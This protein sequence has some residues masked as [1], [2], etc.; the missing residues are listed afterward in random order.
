MT[1]L[2]ACLI[3]FQLASATQAELDDTN[4]AASKSSRN[5]NRVAINAPDTIEEKRSVIFKRSS[6]VF[7]YPP[8]VWNEDEEEGDEE[9]TE[10]DLE[11][12]DAPIKDHSQEEDVEEDEMPMQ[13]PDMADQSGDVQQGYTEDV[14]MDR[15]APR[16]TSAIPPTLQAGNA[17]GAPQPS[18][19]SPVKTQPDQQLPLRNQSSQER[20][21]AQQAEA[22]DKRAAPMLDPAEETGTRKLVITP[23]IARD[24]PAQEQPKQQ[25]Q[26]GPGPLL[27]SAI[28]QKRQEQM[29]LE[30]KRAR[31]EI[32]AA[33]E[34]SRR[35]GTAAKGI[36]IGLGQPPVQSQVQPQKELVRTPS[37]ETRSSSGSGSGGGKLRK[38]RSEKDSD[39]SE[40]DGGKKKKGMFGGLFS[41]NKNK[42]KGGKSSIENIAAVAAGT[43]GRQRTSEE[44]GATSSTHSHTPSSLTASQE[45]GRNAPSPSPAGRGQ[46]QQRTVTPIPQQQTPSRSMAASPPPNNGQQQTQPLTLQVSQHA[47][48]LRDRDQQQQA[49]YSEY[50]KRSP[51]SPPDQPSYA[52]QP[53]SL[54]MPMSEAGSITNSPN[55]SGYGLGLAPVNSSF[56]TQGGRPGSLILTP[57][58]GGD[59]QGSGVP[60]LSVIRVFAGKNLQ[61]EATFK[62]VLLNTSTTAADLVR[63]SMQRFRLAAGE[64]AAD[65]YL[66]VKQVEGTSLRLKPEEKPLGVFE[67]LVEE[68]EEM[69]LRIKRSSMGSI[70]SI[71]SNLSALPAIRKLPMNDFTDDSAVKFYL[72]RE[73][74]DD[75]PTNDSQVQATD[76]PRTEGEALKNGQY[77]SVST[78]GLNTVEPERFSSPALRFAMQLVIYPE[79]L[80]E[81]M[82]FDPHTEA[83][84][85][86]ETL[87]DR[88]GSNATVSPGVS[89]KERKKFFNLPKNIT[90]AE[91]IE[92]GLERFGILEG[93]V[94]G[95]DEV[96]DKLT[97]RRSTSR[98]R[99]TLMVSI[100]KQGKQAGYYFLRKLIASIYRA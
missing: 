88:S 53:A 62:T 66:T 1:I 93:V 51:S 80:P 45:L 19:S 91:V 96:E 87:R 86:K 31:E 100:D 59:G 30:R 57:A 85:F 54:V 98:V 67:Q 90:V 95:G 35:R 12:E 24:E 18:G 78:N 47:S 73:G 94:D 4:P 28:L 11:I 70:S 33:E 50:L 40:R 16:Q 72:N 14:D 58:L 8:A 69:P 65:Y 74:G 82:V 22:E 52:T 39:D 27:P 34:A 29:D 20:L 83:I 41:R 5:R 48:S 79:E 55:T 23:S 3:S 71:A 75:S 9:W 2:Q 56:R 64:D 81:N 6:S 63:Q 38:E 32:E 44:S 92:L 15:S 97:K 10:S 77:L 89:Q 61:S 26:A 49:L 46:P 68:A 76:T 25:Q 42:D 17:A 13:E 37:Q 84:V 21:L 7:R 99:Y 36:N 60:E 43:E